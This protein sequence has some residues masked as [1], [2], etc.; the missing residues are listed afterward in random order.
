MFKPFNKPFKE[1]EAGRIK[2]MWER[3]EAEKHMALWAGIFFFM[4]LIVFLWMVNT[5]NLFD[6]Y[7]VKKSGGL[8]VTE[9]T[10]EFEQ[11]WK[12]LKDNTVDMKVQ[13]GEEEIRKK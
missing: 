12:K 13:G 6:Y 4:T 10:S 3:I 2:V 9:F 1:N 8:D 11:A 5:K 7:N